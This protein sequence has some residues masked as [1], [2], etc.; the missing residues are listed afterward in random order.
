MK[1]DEQTIRYI[2]YTGSHAFRV[3]KQLVVNV[4]YLLNNNLLSVEKEK[5]APNK[6]YQDYI[7]NIESG[8]IPKF[9]IEG[10]QAGHLALKLVG[11]DY[12]ENK[13][14]KNIKFEHEFEGY[15]PDIITEDNKIIIECGSTNPDKVF[16]YFKNKNLQKV[17]IIPYPDVD[18]RNIYSYVF[19]P[20]DELSNFLVFREKE[21]LNDIRKYKQ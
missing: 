16:Y 20:G 11:R 6:I 21:E 15:K 9:D 7:N 3:D 4:C 13:G 14:F 10:G 8:K 19:I 2:F 1:C 18:D 5:I 12:L 17:I